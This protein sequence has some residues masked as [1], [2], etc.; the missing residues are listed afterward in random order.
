MVVE[1]RLNWVLERAL[2]LLANTIC[3]FLIIVHLILLSS[4][5]F[6]DRLLSK[7]LLLLVRRVVLD[8]LFGPVGHYVR[9]DEGVR[10]A[11]EAELDRVGARLDHDCIRASVV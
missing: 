1:I 10:L 6:P 9:H 3:H 2:D 8:A 11:G 5:H 7:Q 4:R